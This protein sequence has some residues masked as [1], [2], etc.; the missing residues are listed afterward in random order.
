MDKKKELGKNIKNYR[1]L[2]NMSQAELAEQVGC[3]PSAIAMYETGKRQPDLDTMEAIADVLNV[4]IRDLVPGNDGTEYVP[5]TI[6]ARIVSFG[7]DNLPGQD[8]KKILT[9]LRTMY[10]NNPKIFKKGDENE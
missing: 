7:M 1:R 8:R 6:E 5:K 9:I 4:R 3:S 2:R 10:M